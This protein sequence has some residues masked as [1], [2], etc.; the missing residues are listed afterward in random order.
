[1]KN[2][3]E[4]HGGDV[5]QNLR[6]RPKHPTRFGLSP[7]DDT[8]DNVAEEF[9]PGLTDLDDLAEDPDLALAFVP[10]PPE[11]LKQVL[12]GVAGADLEDRPCPSRDH[13]HRSERR[14]EGQNN[15]PAAVNGLE[16]RRKNGAGAERRQPLVE[17][18]LELGYEQERRRSLPGKVPGPGH[19]G[20]A[21]V[22]SALFV[23]QHA[24]HCHSPFYRMAF[25]LLVVSN[26]H[27]ED[28]IAAR[29]AALVN[30][31][32]LALPVMGKGS[33]YEGLAQVE[34]LEPRWAP[35]SGGFPFAS[36]KNLID[37]LKAGLLTIVPRQIRAVQQVRSRVKAVL[38]V[39]DAYALFLGWL[40]SARGHKPLFHLQPLISAHYLK[41]RHWLDRLRHLN[42]LG[43]EDFLWFERWL[44][45][46]AR[47]VYVRDR[48]TESRA[49]NLGIA[50]AVFYGSFAMD[51]L[52]PP[53]RPLDCSKPVIALLPGTR[54]DA[55][56]SLPI[57]IQAAS[58]LP[59]FE[60][61]VAWALPWEKVML[62]PGFSLHIKS[63]GQAL[64]TNGKVSVRLEKGAFSAI[65]HVARVAI[66][67]AGTANE[68]AAG[69]GIPV[70]GFPT[71][72]PQYTRAFAERQKRL[73]GDALHL[74]AADPES[75]AEAAQRLVKPGEARKR[76]SSAARERLW[77]KGALPRIACELKEAL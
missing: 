65:L 35:P 59:E 22:E 50:Q 16:V 2:L 49:Q 63:H 26:G 6:P 71:P 73:L 58:L 62:P 52:G 46:S 66:G 42:E 57:M 17:P 36:A 10:Q 61:V 31:P 12:A 40:A 39:G 67:T 51:M 56:F 69:L 64:A 1:M 23:Y 74:V 70:V 29:V 27:A 37:D 5:F 3:E 7:N 11:V 20:Q 75:I 13:R 28:A 15:V 55:S 68:Q 45:R 34:L 21:W 41:G 48:L 4:G 9:K 60:A 72:G 14:F 24:L 76:A 19:L 30:H 32:T 77:P 53:E 38:A 25:V 8:F 54:A 18:E 44:Q 33:P 43:A 47:K